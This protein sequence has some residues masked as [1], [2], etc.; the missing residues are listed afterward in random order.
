LPLIEQ[1][2]SS[3][4]RRKGM[5]PDQIEEFSAIVKLRL[6]E[7]DYAII[8]AFKERSSFAT[9]IAAV[10]S[11][12]ILNYR[13]REWGKWRPSAAALQLGEIAVKLERMVYREGRSLDDAAIA[14]LEQDPDVSR[15]DL[16][17]L[18]GKLPRRTKRRFVELNEAELEPRPAEDT[19]SERAAVAS[20][21][22]VV[23]CAFIDELPDEDQ[24]IFRLRFD[25]DMSVAQISRALHLDQQTLYRRLY[26]RFKTLRERLEAAGVRADD[27]ASVIGHDTEFLDFQ[28]KNRGR[29]L[30]E[31]DESTVATRQEETRHDR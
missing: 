6:I 22:S 24:L 9:Y 11:R 17:I 10:I 23:V 8:R 12:N 29:R 14:I 13:D 5:N 7:N 28:L 1:I 4:C 26:N 2:I 3:I 16:D 20:Q 21:I 25:A 27:V 30:S 18:Y 19:A 15:Q 31:E